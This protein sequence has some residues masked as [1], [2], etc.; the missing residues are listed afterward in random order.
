MKKI[1][2]K[3]SE[4]ST[5]ERKEKANMPPDAVKAGGLRV[6]EQERTRENGEWLANGVL[7]GDLRRNQSVARNSRLWDQK[8][9]VRRARLS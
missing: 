8:N 4:H 9:S 6:A 2:W 7:E 1:Y 5:P 3:A